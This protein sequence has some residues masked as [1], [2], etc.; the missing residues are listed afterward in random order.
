VSKT[1]GVRRRVRTIKADRDAPEANVFD[2]PC[3]IGV[4]QRAVGCQRGGQPDTPGFLGKLPHVRPHER[5][6]AREDQDRL[7]DVR[8]GADEGERLLGRQHANRFL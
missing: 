4:H 7:A 5:L 8:D 1:T 6:A 3:D 2:P